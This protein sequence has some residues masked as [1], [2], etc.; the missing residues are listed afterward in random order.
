MTRL[1]YY[2]MEVARPSSPMPE[3]PLLDD[4]ANDDE[5]SQLHKS[6]TRAVGSIGVYV[7]PNA[8]VF[9]DLFV[10]QHGQLFGFPDMLP[11]YIAA[12]I[13]VDSTIDIKEQY[14]RRLQRSVVSKPIALINSTAH[15]VYGHWLLDI[16]SRFWV[17]KSLVGQTDRIPNCLIA[18]TSPSYGIEVLKEVFGFTQDRLITY[19][20]EKDI[21]QAELLLLP[22]LP[23]EDYVFHP[24]FRDYIQFFIDSADIKDAPSTNRIYISRRKYRGKSS[25][26]HRS[27]A[28]EDE[29][30]FILER[31]GF[32]TVYPEDYSI[33]EQVRIFRKAVVVLG[34]AGS[35]LHNTVFCKADT[36]VIS[37]GHINQVQS[38]LANLFSHRL[39]IMR[40]IL[41]TSGTFYS[42]AKI[43]NIVTKYA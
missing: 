10:F 33:L 27:I 39:C 14:I 43:Q 11:Q 12:Q 38:S 8:E 22:S 1:L 2:K 32:M 31:H 18:S 4:S 19:D 23:H 16:W 21:V 15:R 42:P 36:I 34:E 35:G 24:I 26:V 3:T 29:I 41:T 13:Y 17:L 7:I 30:E 25:S 6:T 5:L 9:G 28:N 20:T 40:G 37:L